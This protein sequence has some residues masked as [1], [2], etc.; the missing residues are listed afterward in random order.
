MEH[1]KSLVQDFFRAPSANC[2]I[3]G[4]N[5]NINVLER[6]FKELGVGWILD[7]TRGASAGQR[8]HT[9]TFDTQ[10]WIRALA[11]IT[12]A[13]RLMP[14]LFPDGSS[15]GENT[16]TPKQL[17]F[18]HFFQETMLRMLTFVDVNV[19]GLPVSNLDPLTLE[20]LSSLLHVHDALVQGSNGDPVAIP[21]ATICTSGVDREQNG[22][23][24]VSKG[25]QGG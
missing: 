20:N 5:G 9:Y 4:G 2:S 12:E 11:E 13:I 7:V 16:S 25:N 24:L 8:E 19:S 15:G 1:I 14:L 22:Q 17:Q 23:P 18:E 6:W 21:F 10:S 3:N